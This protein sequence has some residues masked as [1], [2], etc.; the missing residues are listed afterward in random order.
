MFLSIHI[1][2]PINILT[3]RV[4]RCCA[5]L[6]LNVVFNLQNEFPDILALWSSP[7]K[8]CRDH[9]YATWADD[10]STT[11]QSI[12]NLCAY[13]I[14]LDISKEMVSPLFKRLFPI[15]MDIFMQ[16]ACQSV[17]AYNF[18]GTRIFIQVYNNEK[19]EICITSSVQG[20]TGDC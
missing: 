15:I 5:L 18:I 6:L 9:M 10:I 13:C 2:V 3:V 12:T 7:S 1:A 20:I 4:A 14:W 19:S 16:K 17:N 11:K 8:R